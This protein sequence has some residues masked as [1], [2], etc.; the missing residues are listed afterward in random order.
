MNI[1]IGEKDLAEIEDYK[2]A[3]EAWLNHK[4][5]SD[6]KGSADLEQ[7][8]LKRAAR[9]ALVV[10]LKTD[11]QQTLDRLIKNGELS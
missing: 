6:G 9:V 10:S 8:M 3:R 2:E 1:D 7:V 11:C 5:A 4:P